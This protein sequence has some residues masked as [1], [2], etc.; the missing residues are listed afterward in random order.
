[1]FP[2]GNRRRAGVI[3]SSLSEEVEP[4]LKILSDKHQFLYFLIFNSH[5]N[6]FH[7]RICGV[8]GVFETI[9]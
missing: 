9:M 3:E 2:L 5:F 8:R 6:I 7:L 1:M 4:L